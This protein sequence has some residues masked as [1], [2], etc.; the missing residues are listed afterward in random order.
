MVAHE[1]AHQAVMVV[2]LAEQ[3]DAASRGLT[4][5]AKQSGEE[6]QHRCVACLQLAGAQRCKLAEPAAV[7]GAVPRVEVVGI[8]AVPRV[9]VVP[10]VEVVGI[11]VVEVVATHLLLLVEY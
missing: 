8:E 11:E 1:L 7:S 3:T 6:K 2:H 10:H 4:M 9:E 5:Q